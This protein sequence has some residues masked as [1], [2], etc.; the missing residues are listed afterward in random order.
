MFASLPMYDL[1]QIR[2][3]TDVLWQLIRGRLDDHGIEAPAG[4]VRG[5]DPHMEWLRADLLLSQTCGLPFVKDL[6]GRVQ[7]LGSPSYDI[8]CGSGSYYSVIIAREDDDGELSALS[9]GRFACNDQRS[10][11]GHA[12]WLAHMV[13]ND[14]PLPSS[15]VFTGA[16]L[17]SV[18]AVSRG[19]AEFATIDAVT[20]EL[21][22][23]HMPEANK[24]RVAGHTAA[25]PSLPYITSLAFRDQADV[26]RQAISEAI[27]GMPAGDRDALLLTGF[28]VRQETDYQPLADAWNRVAHVDLGQLSA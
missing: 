17:A 12:A 1:P 18:A 20:W 26:I 10:Q 15:V 9:A 21:A 8:D 16:H 28:V 5:S 19:E 13:D 3:S 22:L 14:L 24:L 27:A 2:S 23:R 6:Q 11:S 25:M 4:L 7:M